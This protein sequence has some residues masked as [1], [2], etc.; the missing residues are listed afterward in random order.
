MDCRK[1]EEKLPLYFYDELAAEECAQIEA[2]LAA[3]TGC[4][5]AAAEWGRLRGALNERPLLEPSPELLVR[6]RLGLEEALDREASGWRAL[7][8]SGFGLWPASSALRVTAALGILLVGFSMGWTVRRQV[9]SPMTAS[10]EGPSWIGAD[11]TDARI[12]SIS[13]VVPG[14]QTGDVR[15][16]LDAERR[17]TLEGSLDDPRIQQVL[18]YAA[19]SYDNPGIRHDTLEVLRARSSNPAVRD[20]LLHAVR[21][22]PNDGVRLEA[23]QAL[24]ELPWSGEIRDIVLHILERDTNP[25]VRV[26]AINLLAEHAG[27]DDLPTLE[28]L[29]TQD[30]NPYVRLKC[31]NAL[32]ERARGEF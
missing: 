18:L 31:T 9:P 23:L 16:T 10:S 25:G 4:A 14:P 24:Q 19:K 13:R 17:F 30:R 27:E 21:Y 2:H 29:A 11:L 26:A 28:Q 3:C 6:C 8:R 7:V 12:N 15:I 32:R 1:V 5:A 22:D 20:A